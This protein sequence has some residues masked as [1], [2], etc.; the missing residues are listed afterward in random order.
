MSVADLLSSQFCWSR[1]PD[2]VQMPAA[3]A[4]SLMHVCMYAYFSDITLLITSAPCMV[5]IFSWTLSVNSD[6]SCG[7]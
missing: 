6:M 4:L 3:E 7:K 5:V 2:D 1:G